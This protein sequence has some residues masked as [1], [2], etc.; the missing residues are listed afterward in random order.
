MMGE[1]KRERDRQ[2]AVNGQSDREHRLHRRAQIAEGQLSR[3]EK[4]QGSIYYGVSADAL[5]KAGYRRLPLM[6]VTQEELE[7]VLYMAKKHEED[8]NRIRTQARRK[9]EISEAYKKH[10][11]EQE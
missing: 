3:L 4:T 7:L 5:R 2:D 8:V 11:G 10:Q 9:V 6:W 1:A